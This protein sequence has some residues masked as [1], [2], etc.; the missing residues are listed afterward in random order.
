MDA[1]TSQLGKAALEKMTPTSSSPTTGTSSTSF[2]KVLEF[3][4]SQGSEDMMG[5]L[6]EFVDNTFGK[7]TN[8]PAALDA[9]SIHIDVAKV[10]EVQ[11]TPSSGYFYDFVKDFNKDQLQFDNLKEMITSGRS[12]KPQELLAMQVG[13][14]HMTVMLEGVTKGVEQ[15]TRTVNTVAQTNVG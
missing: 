10:G 1:I 14:Q 15:T 9:S 4:N 11:K 7:Q 13:I 12:F 5:K 6:N 8:G 3:Q 2:Q